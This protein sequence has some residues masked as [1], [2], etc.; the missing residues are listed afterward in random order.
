MKSRYVTLL[1]FPNA[2]QAH[3]VRAR[4]ESEG[5]RVQLLDENINYTLGPTI[6]HGVRLQVLQDQVI[7]AK[8]IVEKYLREE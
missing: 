8:S 4:L 7:R 5:I 2:I 3:M 1:Q 6:I